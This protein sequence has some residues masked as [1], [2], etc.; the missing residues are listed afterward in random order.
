[1]LRLMDPD[2]GGRHCSDG[3]E[4]RRVR[5]SGKTMCFAGHLS[6]LSQTACCRRRVITEVKA[7]GHPR[8]DSNSTTVL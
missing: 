8:T 1:M 3:V 5:H 2:G 4:T 6:T 7:V